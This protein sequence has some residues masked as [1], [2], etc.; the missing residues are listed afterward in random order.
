[1]AHAGG[2]RSVVGGGF[3]AVGLL[4]WI[5]EAPILMR[6][7]PEQP[8]MVQNTHRA[9]GAHGTAVRR[10]SA[11]PVH[12]PAHPRHRVPDRCRSAFSRARHAVLRPRAGLMAVASSPGPGGKQLRRLALPAIVV[13]ALLGLAV[14]RLLVALGIDSVAS[15][16]A[17]LATVTAAAG[18]LGLLATAIPLN[19]ASDALDASRPHVRAL[20]EHAS[21]AVFLADMTGRYLRARRLLTQLSGEDSCNFQSIFRR[22]ASVPRGIA[23][24]TWS[25]C[26]TRERSRSGPGFRTFRLNDACAR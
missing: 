16:V 5:A 17:L 21:E 1:M 3:G 20:I 9:D 18:L 15:V 22:S 19:R 14:T 2:E 13:P 7:I 23:H 11:L 26:A 4:G 12:G 8:A 24:I 25:Q 10:G 6:F